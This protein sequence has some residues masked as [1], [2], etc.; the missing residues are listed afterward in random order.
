MVL[1]E[2]VDDVWRLDEVLRDELRWMLVRGSCCS[3]VEKLLRD[4]SRERL[5]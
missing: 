4:D 5:E 3:T 2:A 1:N